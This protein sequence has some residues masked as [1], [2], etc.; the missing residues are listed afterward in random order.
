M[1]EYSEEYIK[2]K[3]EIFT[4]GFPR[5]GNTWLDRILSDVLRAPLQ[6][7]PDEVIEYFGPDPHDGDYVVRKSHFYANQYNGVGY[8]GFPSKIVWIQRDP[9]D[10]A[11]SVMFYRRAQPDLMSVLKSVFLNQNIPGIPVI[12]Y[13]WFME[14]WLASDDLTYSTKYET[15]HADP[16]NEIRR[17][18]KA[19]TGKDITVKEA[20]QV[21]YRQRFDRWKT[22]YPHSMRRGEAGNWRKYFTKKEGSF[23]TA[24]AGDLM[25]SQ[26]YIKNF[27]WWKELPDE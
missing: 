14:G 6:T 1:D 13:R 18:Y 27:D 10:M 26:G 22:R 21:A 25:L 12:G 2:G 20:E 9:R 11:V 24:A 4:T 3:E 23:L 7:K 17:I 8:S 16:A 19:V 15:L 5:C